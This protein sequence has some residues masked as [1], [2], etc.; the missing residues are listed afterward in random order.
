MPGSSRY[1]ASHELYLSLTGYPPL[2]PPQVC[3]PETVLRSCRGSTASQ[4]LCLRP[5]FDST[6]QERAITRNFGLWLR[7]M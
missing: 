3:F 2:W 7:P 5:T 1:W 6:I 4:C